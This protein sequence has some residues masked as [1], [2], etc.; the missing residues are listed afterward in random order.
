MDCLRALRAS[1]VNWSCTVGRRRRDWEEREL[2]ILRQAF[3][4]GGV[5]AVFAAFDAAGLVRPKREVILRAAVREKLSEPA[6]SAK[7]A[8]P[9]ERLSPGQQIMRAQDAP[10]LLTD[11][12]GLCLAIGLAAGE[13]RERTQQLSRV[14]QE[15]ARRVGAD[16]RGGAGEDDG[17]CGVLRAAL[18]ALVG[19]VEVGG[20]ED[21]G[22]CAPAQRAVMPSAARR[23]PPGTAGRSV[24]ESGE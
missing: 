11:L 8:R 7:D 6:Q 21:G 24:Y 23:N 16:R 4:R 3:P 20:R 13:L 17:Q 14:T 19:E 12:H 2:V 1:V 5:N 9:R 18:A 22:E 10:G 15:I